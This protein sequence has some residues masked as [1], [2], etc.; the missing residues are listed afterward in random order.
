MHARAPTCSTG[1]CQN[2]L[3]PRLMPP[4][5]EEQGQGSQGPGKGTTSY[6]V[7]AGICR[8]SCPVL[9][10]RLEVHRRQVCWQIGDFSCNTEPPNCRGPC[11]ATNTQ[12]PAFVA[13]GGLCARQVRGS[14]W[15]RFWRR[16]RIARGQQLSLK[17]L[18]HGG[19]SVLALG[20][21]WNGCR[22]LTSR[23][24]SMPEDR[25]L[26]GLHRA[27]ATPCCWLLLVSAKR[28]ALH[29]DGMVRR[30]RLS[31]SQCLPIYAGSYRL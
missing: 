27:A 11:A 24:S 1:F 28:T 12:D 20:G 19:Q 18:C 10:T 8:L 6:N 3:A 31:D 26:T 21:A 30:R 9:T 23:P 17:Q 13:V 15:P 16:V 7:P 22:Q 2:R 29:Q 4:C 25:I 14:A 5:A